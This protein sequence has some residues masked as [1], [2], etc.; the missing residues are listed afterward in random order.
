M[1]ALSEIRQMSFHEKLQVMEALRE[2]ISREEDRVEV[3]QW[4]RDLLDERESLVREGKAQFLD[5]ETA[6]KQ[7]QDATS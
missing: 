1:I 3:L 5:W 7:I 6:K 2:E 4:H